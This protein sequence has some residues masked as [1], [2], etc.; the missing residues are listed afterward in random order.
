[1]TDDG[2]LVIRAGDYYSLGTPAVAEALGAI[3][4][5]LRTA[6]A[7]V[8]DLRSA[9]PTEL[10]GRMQLTAALRE[11]E[12]LLLPDT[13][14]AP[15]QW[16]R[17]Y[18][19]H[20]TPSPFSSGQYRTGT[21]VES[22][23]RLIP[24]AD[25]RPLPAIFLVNENAG[26]V[27]SVAPLQ[28][29]GRAL[30]V[31]EGDVAQH[32]IGE[33]STV[34]LAEGLTAQVRT[35]EAVFPDGSSAA[36]QADAIVNGGTTSGGDAG[37]E[38]AL[39]LARAFEPSRVSRRE[40][41]ARVVLTRDRTYPGMRVPSLEYRLLA[42]FRIWNAIEYFYPYKPLLDHD[43]GDVLPEIL[44]VFEA[45]SDAESYARAVAAMARRIQDSH[46]YVS[47]PAF[48]ENVIGSGYVPI[49][50]R[51]IEN[52]PIVTHV[53]DT[54]AA[55]V[56][57]IG[58]GD[59]VIA[60]DGEDAGERL[61]R[62]RATISA[63]TPWSLDDRASFSFMNG[64]PGSV[65]RLTLRDE[66]GRVKQVEIERRREDY[67]TLYHRERRGEIVRILAGNIGYVDLD[68]LA[69]EMVDPMF[70]T[71][72]ETSAIIFD[73]RGYPNG[74]IW[75]IA[76]RLTEKASVVARFETPLVGHPAPAAASAAF[77]QTLEPAPSQFVYRGR[78]VMLMDERSVS[79]AEHT[80]LYLK[81]ANNTLFVGS[82]TAG[83]NGEITSV[84]V[85]GGLTVG[86]TGQSV[87]HPDGRVLQRTGLAPDL[88]VKP[89]IAGIRSGV[90]E[91][92]EAALELL[93]REI[94][95]D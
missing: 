4:D 65:A 39:A 93:S 87:R 60:V 68:R 44:P 53:Y 5:A 95:R 32:T 35:A 24:S 67:N 6:R 27:Q 40:L 82:R 71:L 22:G 23:T 43:W 81:A 18:T 38:R 15:G 72:R 36:F 92:L 2:I 41:P 90:D 64:S 50:V 21:F 83:A 86:F 52:T 11:V 30:V 51:L 66:R 91:V 75:A 80:G 76:P 8:F 29:A 3:G 70:E 33:A 77:A 26:V 1:V 61:T 89:T 56:A 45:A 10:F 79:Q 7:V 74:T 62:F 59:V 55:R 12:R 31:F 34:S 42:A 73:M 28:K 19:G 57:G 54:A 46:A 37:L 25:A 94:Q 78:T 49:R 48:E 13:L 63:S 17:V 14:D 20:E 16:R 85:P 9:S 88:E 84:S 69:Y 47:G 58:V